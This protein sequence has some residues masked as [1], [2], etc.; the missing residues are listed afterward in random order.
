M[1]YLSDCNFQG[2]VSET[3]ETYTDRAL[4][5]F[6]GD[7]LSLWPIFFFSAFHFDEIANYVF[8]RAKSLQA[9]QKFKLRKEQLVEKV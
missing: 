7:L 3:R 5:I 9:E 2:S 4:E 8:E 6:T 1:N